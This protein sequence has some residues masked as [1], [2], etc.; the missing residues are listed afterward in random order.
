MS[1]SSSPTLSIITVICKDEILTRKFYCCSVLLATL[2][3]GTS[4]YNSS[5]PEDLIKSRILEIYCTVPKDSPE[6]YV[7]A[8]RRVSTSHDVKGVSTDSARSTYDN[9]DKI[10]GHPFEKSKKGNITEK[11]KSK[12]IQEEK[13]SRTTLENIIQTFKLGKL[14]SPKGFSDI[15]FDFRPLGKRLSQPLVVSYLRQKCEKEMFAVSNPKISSSNN[16]NNNNNNNNENNNINDNNNNNNNENNNS[17]NNNN[18]FNNNNHDNNKNHNMNSI[19]KNKLK[20]QNDG[21][22]VYSSTISFTIN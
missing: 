5:I 1:T 15:S 9:K 16:E 22:I 12:N 18:N 11:L 7:R 8:A 13:R 17:S 4:G 14:L 3:S 20:I 2:L 19:I 10:D 6:Q 21:L